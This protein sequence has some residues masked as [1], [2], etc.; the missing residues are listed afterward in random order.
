MSKTFSSS[1]TRDSFD[2]RPRFLVRFSARI[3]VEAGPTF[4][5]FGFHRAGFWKTETDPRDKEF[6]VF[7]CEPIRTRIQASAQHL[8]RNLFDLG[9]VQK[10]EHRHVT[11]RLVDRVDNQVRAINQF[12]GARVSPHARASVGEGA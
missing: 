7:D 10:A 8:L 2:P 11:S 5:A 9:A 3:W 4:L 12:A 1:I 6:R